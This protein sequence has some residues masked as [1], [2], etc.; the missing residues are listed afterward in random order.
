MLQDGLV[1]RALS[2]VAGVVLLS[3]LRQEKAVRQALK[4]LRLHVPWKGEN[5]APTTGL[6]LSAWVMVQHPQSAQLT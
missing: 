6:A 5:R 3:G 2:D 4:E 1:W